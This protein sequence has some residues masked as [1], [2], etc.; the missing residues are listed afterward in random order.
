LIY[1]GRDLNILAASSIT[2]VSWAARDPAFEEYSL[3]RFLELSTVITLPLLFKI[4][5][6]C[7]TKVRNI[8]RFA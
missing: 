7:I 4:Y 8:C 5:R 6:F 1:N 2:V 3:T